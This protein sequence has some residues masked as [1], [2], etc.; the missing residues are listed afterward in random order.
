MK[1]LSLKRR[2]LFIGA[3]STVFVLTLTAMDHLFPPPLEKARVISTVV[4]DHRGLPLR[5][6]PIAEGRWR[7][8]TDL[9]E[10]DPA[11]IEALL[12]IEDKRFYRHYGVDVL[13]LSRA[14]VDT[15]R[16]GEVHSG[17]STITM[18]TARLL[19]P[20]PRT[21]PSKMIEVFRALQ[22]ERRLSK[23]EILSLYLTLAPYGGNI[24]GLRTASWV[25]FGREP[26]VLTPD[27]IALLIALP[28][29][30]EVRRPDRHPDRAKR[31]RYAILHQLEK[32]G[33]LSAAIAK[34]A[35]D[36]T[37]PTHR[38]PFPALAWHASEF[39]YQRAAQEGAPSVTSTLDYALQQETEAVITEVVKDLG[40]GVQAAALIVDL[41]GRAVRASVGSAGLDGSGGWLD[42]TARA[43]SP[44]STL[45]PIIYAMAFDD[46]IAAPHTRID[47]L[48]ARFAS[49][50]PENFD[51][52]FRGQ[53]TIAEALQHSLNVPA[54]R[55]LDR[56]GTDRFLSALRFA[57][58]RPVL[59]RSTVRD[60]GLAVAL[61]GIGLS[62]QDL[63]VLYGALG[64][65]GRALP[66]AWTSSAATENT[67]KQGRSLVSAESASEIIRILQNSPAPPGR[68]PASLSE[69]APLIAYKTGTSY[70]YRDAWAAGIG[71]G[72]VIIVW[73]GRP[74][75]APR[76]GVTGR[77][78]ALPALMTLF[79]ALVR[80][81]GA[82]AIHASY[83]DGAEVQD[84]PYQTLSQF[85][86]GVRPP[87]ILFPPENAELWAEGPEHGF[88]LSASGDG[89]LR[90]F[91]DGQPLTS[92]QPS[93]ARWSPRMQGFYML[94]VADASGRRASTKVRVRMPVTP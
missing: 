62:A 82:S 20:R 67:A 49:Y 94:T 35:S 39:I 64:D 28:Q 75:G 84:T 72:H 6:F 63:A 81:E 45:K 33:L 16:R 85:D 27:Q 5:A 92:A 91:V 93:D 12:A 88:A 22:I 66:L 3:L 68:M 60:V 11:F 34:D 21:I 74:D 13:A 59:S 1:L 78:A 51:R 86:V 38:Q 87:A 77:K 65:E 14:L 80:T 47:D 83:D 24:E 57:G 26:D 7:L 17:A 19:E 41:E 71:A 56:V 79:D 10:V 58:G 76:P 55:V 73:T 25:W 18:Q 54:V 30:P 61:G 23:R 89:P 52:T 69:R 44:G 31:A 40:E 29:S 46:G 15:A 70:G 4:T 37:V 53:V 9:D 48:P 50:R 42:L 32:K 36:E 90:W 2:L 8:Q 43:R